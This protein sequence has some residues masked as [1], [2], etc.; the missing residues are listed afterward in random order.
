MG[1]NREAVEDSIRATFTWVI[2][3]G[4]F[5]VASVIA[6]AVA[7]W[8]TAGEYEEVSEDSAYHAA[9]KF[10][11]DLVGAIAQNGFDLQRDT[12]YGGIMTFQNWQDIPFGAIPLPNKFVPYIAVKRADDNRPGFLGGQWTVLPGLAKDVGVGADG[13][14]WVIGTNPVGDAADFGVYK[15]NGNDWNG[16]G[17]GGVRIAGAPDGTAWLVNSVGNIYQWV[18]DHYV[19][20]PGLGKDISVGADGS[21]WLIGTNPVGDAADFGVYKWNGSNW[22]GIGGGGVSISASPDGKA[23]LVNSVG[24]IFRLA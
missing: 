4:E 19:L 23:W 8:A 12:I 22:V 10:G 5:S 2:F 17:G 15:W 21:I 9:G 14:A 7:D 24:N 1:H 11:M 16:V 13:T 6:E 18:G 3:D 20:K